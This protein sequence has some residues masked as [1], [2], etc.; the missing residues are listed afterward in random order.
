MRRLVKIFSVLA[1]DV[2]V[3]LMCICLMTQS[4]ALLPFG[5]VIGN[6]CQSV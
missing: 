4:S 5:A 3:Y 2:S 6:T 1:D